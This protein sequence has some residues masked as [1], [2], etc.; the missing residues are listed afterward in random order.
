MHPSLETV[1]PPHLP[2]A[3]FT[4]PEWCALRA[5]RDLLGKRIKRLENMLA[6]AKPGSLASEAI[7]R[8]GLETLRDE[9]W[10]IEFALRFDG[11][12]RQLDLCK[13]SNGRSC[14]RC[15]HWLLDW[16]ECPTCEVPF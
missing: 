10:H 8:E 7:L 9:Y 3:L 13:R 6:Q 12:L 16:H 15:G 14:K 2:P 11:D 5:E 1:T 4:D